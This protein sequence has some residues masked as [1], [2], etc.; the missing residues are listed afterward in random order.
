MEHSFEWSIVCRNLWL[1]INNRA[2]MGDY[3]GQRQ[4][5]SIFM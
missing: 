1:R 3:L 4:F 2:K 5:L